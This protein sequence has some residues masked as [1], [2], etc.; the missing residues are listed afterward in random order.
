MKE[1]PPSRSAAREVAYR[2][3]L[4]LLD[5]A[6]GSLSRSGV[7]VRLQDQPF[8]LL[9]LLLERA[10][11]VVSREDIQR[12]LWPVNTFVEFDKSL[13]V[14]VLKVR[15]SLGDEAN[16]PRF[17]E[18]IPRR[19]YRFIAPVTVQALPATGEPERIEPPIPKVVAAKL[20]EKDTGT[21]G[22][23]WYWILSVSFALALIGF[24]SYKSK[25]PAQP[26][27]TI[28]AN[29]TAPV[30]VRRSI[31]V[32]GFRNLPGRPQEEW[33]STAFAEMLNTEL[34][35]GGELRLV[36]GEDVAR[37]KRE[38][39]LTEED[40]LAKPTLA[41]LQTN[42]GA[43]VVILGSYMLLPLNGH[44]R[45]RLDIR[46]QDTAAGETI[47]EE[48]FT[49]SEDNLFELVSQAGVRVRE[50]LGLSVSLA[51]ATGVTR[52]ALPA[53]QLA[54]R[55][56]T[57]GRGKL[58]AYELV[59]GRDLLVKAVAA[60]PNYP[61]GHSALSEAWSLLG[62]QAKSRVEAKRA[63]ELS[64]NLPQEERLIVQGRYYQSVDDGVKALEVY[65]ELFKRFPDRLDYGLRLA[66]AQRYLKPAD[67]LR[68]LAR[69]RNLPL[70]LGLDPRIDLMES[71]A[72]MEQDL[73]KA[74][75]LA[76]RG[77]AKAA[78]EGS[79]LMVA[80]SYGILCQEPAVAGV[81]VEQQLRECEHARQ[82]FIVAG[83]K[84]NAA[85]TLNDLAAI[86]YRQGNLSK[87]EDAWRQALQAFH[88]L[89]AIEGIVA[90]SNNLG[91]ALEMQGHLSA[92]QKLLEQAIPGYQ[93]LD[94]KDGV[95]RVLADL[96][97]ISL[98]KGDLEVAKN[99]FRKATAIASEIDDKSAAAYGL[100]GLG[101]VLTEQGDLAEA[102]KFYK[103]ALETRLEVREKHSVAETQL[104]LAQLSIEEGHAADVEAEIRQCKEQFRQDQQADDELVAGLLLSRDLRSQSKNTDAQK[105][106]AVNQSLGERTQSRLLGLQYEL[107]S[108]RVELA[109][110]H[111][112]SSRAPLER[113]RREAASAGFARLTFETMLAEGE[114]EKKSGRA[115]AARAQL[116]SLA[117]S[118]H[119]K[120]FELI[121]HKAFAER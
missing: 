111:P 28:A 104:A 105:E 57:E 95:A 72:W 118:A 112:E 22:R 78:A 59:A 69:L 44:N 40:T 97:E 83:D 80:R 47:A 108:A 94:D 16:N 89:G 103:E 23:P 87:A 43:D 93:S 70:P 15:E 11:Q 55:Y 101:D 13:S 107:E 58:W 31:A 92:A 25:V 99:N 73:V 36:S 82:S 33:L 1:A 76:E 84:N 96:G 117:S 64:Q 9:V 91:D 74:R 109:L 35:A 63:L 75:A 8:Q 115:A 34:A 24:A 54:V 102:R 45:I 100:A 85:R 52:V 5:P 86:Y 50:R 60:D 4:F 68:T 10:G 71:S 106:M 61:L 19:G 12:H 41:R 114:L 90:A 20:A 81:S 77:L 67:S 98:Q 110:E 17:V 29:L 18:T 48:A 113:M 38:L 119:N 56:F 32:L 21:W 3:G 79:P 2:F 121:A 30:H 14:A 7:R 66:A 116:T 62:F 53:N 120:G 27:P 39:S 46:L 37:A 51:T 65:Q 88:V 26:A 49:G 42:P 6:S